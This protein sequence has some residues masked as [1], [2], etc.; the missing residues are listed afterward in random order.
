MEINANTNQ[1]NLERGTI[2]YSKENQDNSPEK[3]K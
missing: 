3:K 2:V 1:E